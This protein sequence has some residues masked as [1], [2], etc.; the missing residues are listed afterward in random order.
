MAGLLFRSAHSTGRWGLPAINQD[1][2]DDVI[3]ALPSLRYWLSGQR[4]YGATSVKE[5]AGNARFHRGATTK[6]YPPRAFPSTFDG[7]GVFNFA[8]ATTAALVPEHDGTVIEPNSYSI[9]ML[10]EWTD[11]MAGVAHSIF[12]TRVGWTSGNFGVVIEKSAAGNLSFYPNFTGSSGQRITVAHSFTTGTP[13][14]LAFT[15]DYGTKYGQMFIDDMV[16]PAGTF[17]SATSNVGDA[18]FPILGNSSAVAA[19]MYLADWIWCDAVL[20]SAQLQAA[21]TAL[22]TKYDL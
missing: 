5:I 4:A 1:A 15:Y 12:Q 7:K 22:E 2:N 10:V 20:T 3:A 16:T 6:T 8:S 13:E 18:R 11:A 19:K 21:K 9:L 14:L 17:T